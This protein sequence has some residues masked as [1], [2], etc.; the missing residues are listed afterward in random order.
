MKCARDL[1]GHMKCARKMRQKNRQIF[2]CTYKNSPTK[3]SAYLV[4]A[5]RIIY[6]DNFSQCLLA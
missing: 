5:K 3:V 2:T 4:N 6:A 1:Q